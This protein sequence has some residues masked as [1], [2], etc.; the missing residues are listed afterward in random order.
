MTETKSNPGWG[1]IELKVTFKDVADICR[2]LSRNSG[3]IAK[4]FDS[5]WP[6]RFRDLSRDHAGMVLHL[7]QTVNGYYADG[8]YDAS[9]VW[10]KFRGE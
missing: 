4:V 5:V 9:E 2:L 6:D 10:S 7:I 1:G 3:N 8:R